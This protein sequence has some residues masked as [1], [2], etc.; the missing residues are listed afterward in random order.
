MPMGTYEMTFLGTTETK[1]AFHCTRD[2]PWMLGCF[3]PVV[4]A[5]AIENDKG[6]M[7]PGSIPIIR[8]TCPHCSISWWQELDQ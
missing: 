5:D 6:V 8:L 4:H 7:Q 3:T 1:P 2:D